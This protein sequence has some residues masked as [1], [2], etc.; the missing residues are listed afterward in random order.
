[1]DWRQNAYWHTILI[2]EAA[3][4]WYYKNSFFLKK[5]IKEIYLIFF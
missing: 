2:L 3:I 1:M 4:Q 5:E